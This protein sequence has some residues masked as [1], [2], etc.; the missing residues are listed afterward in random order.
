MI[1]ITVNNQPK[2]DGVT[3]ITAIRDG[4]RGGLFALLRHFAAHLIFFLLFFCV[5]H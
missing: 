3:V 5:F 1:T 2:Q 4:R